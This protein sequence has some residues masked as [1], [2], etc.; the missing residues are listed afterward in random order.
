MKIAQVIT[1]MNIGGAQEAVLLTCMGHIAKGHEV[2]L[3]TGPSEG[4]EGKLLEK[5]LPPP[6]L[7][8]IEVPE[9]ER[10]IHLATDYK[11]Y[12]ALRKIFKEHAYDV[13]HTNSSKAGL[14]G[15]AAAWAEKV[16]LVVHTVHGQAFHRYEKPWKNQIYIWAE[17]FAAK[18]CHKIFAV[19]DAMIQQC[20]EAKVAPRSKYEVVYTGMDL[21]S[22]VNAQRD[23]ALRASLNIPSDA[24]VIGTI[25]RL[26]PLKGYE[27]LTPA[28]IQAVQENPKIHFL[29]LGDGTIRPEIEKMINDAN[30]S[31]NFHVMGMVKPEEVPMYTAQMDALA[32]FSLRE[33]LPRGVVQALAAAKPVVAFNLDGTPEVVK[34]G[35]T[36]YI[37]EPT[38]TTSELVSAMRKLVEDTATRERMGKAGQTFVCKY[39]DWKYMS[40][41][42]LDLYKELQQQIQTGVLQ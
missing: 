39:F 13:V 26:F 11:A 15:R 8:I 10:E 40:D 33:G 2:T 9:L 31:A 20:V 22:F 7:K 34:D 14:V 28:A 16:P 41:R 24:L 23:E 3:I 12:R 18:R 6:E 27:Q 30:V 32:H 5:M 25:A 37:L 35:E 19:A 21:D 29:F 42:V 36:G 4:P 1:R 17:R 38:A